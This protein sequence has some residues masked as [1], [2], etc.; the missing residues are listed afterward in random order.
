M[1][2]IIKKVIC[3]II[4]IIILM[5][6]GISKAA[7]A[8]ETFVNSSNFGKVTEVPTD[9]LNDTQKAQLINSIATTLSY[10]IDMNNAGNPEGAMQFLEGEYDTYLQNYSADFP[11]TRSYI[12]Y[13]LGTAWKD[14]KQ[15]VEDNQEDPDNPGEQ[16]DYAQKFDQIYEEYANLSE[17]DKNNNTI[18]SGIERRLR[19]QYNHLTDEEK[20]ENNRTAKMEE[21]YN[22][23]VETDTPITE[24]IENVIDSD[25]S[26][27]KLG[28]SSASASHKMDDII[29]GAEGFLNKGTATIPINGDNLKKGSSTLYNILL[30]VGI[31]LAVAVGMYLGAKFMVSTAEDRAKVKEALIPYIA[32]CI[33]IFTAFAVWRVAIL[34]LGGIA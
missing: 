12:G 10:A 7:S 4:S 23:S 13:K 29:G 8:L 16:N 11:N 18:V 9:D 26:T 27:G 6:P 25:P 32:G 22:K 14:Y 31:F 33:V 17:E 24:V 15:A 5:L 28:S 20:R 1:S 3:I 30:S 21:V 2:N 19:N 34:L